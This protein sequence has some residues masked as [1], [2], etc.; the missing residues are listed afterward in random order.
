MMTREEAVRFDYYLSIAIAQ[1]K[2][3]DDLIDMLV[4]HQY[5]NPVDVLDELS[6]RLREVNA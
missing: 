5:E 3:S 1:L 6:A 4:R 2:R